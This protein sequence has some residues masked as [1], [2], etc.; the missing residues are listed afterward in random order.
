MLNLQDQA[1][2]GADLDSMNNQVAMARTHVTV[3]HHTTS[4]EAERDRKQVGSIIP[5]KSKSPVT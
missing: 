5:F 1:G 3:S 2:K 4:Y